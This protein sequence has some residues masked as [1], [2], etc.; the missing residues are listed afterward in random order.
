MN[1]YELI[2][3]I[4]GD[5]NI[6]YNPKNRTYR[7]EITGNVEEDGIYFQKIASFIEKKSINKV[8]IRIKKEKKGIGL[9][10]HINDKKYVEYLINV[11]G[12]PY[13]PKTFT[14]K[15]PNKFLNWRYSKHIIRGICESDGSIYFSKSKFGK[16]PTYPRIEIRTSSHNLIKQI[17]RILLQRGYSVNLLECD[18]TAK[19]YVSGIKMFYKWNQE[20]GFTNFKNISKFMLWSRLGYYIPKTNSAER[21]NIL[22][23]NI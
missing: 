1:L 17:M 5:G 4:I 6:I 19:I 22:K 18:K 20:I 3:I 14:I 7:L 10:L 11:L 9:R 23:D 13:G 12:L 15:I 2:G 8:H 16:Y 21:V